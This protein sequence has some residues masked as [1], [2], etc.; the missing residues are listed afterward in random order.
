V[1]LDYLQLSARQKG[2][3]HITG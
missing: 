2:K 1:G 3:E